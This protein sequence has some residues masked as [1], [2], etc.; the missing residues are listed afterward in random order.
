MATKK[1]VGYFTFVKV[2]YH[3]Y[4]RNSSDNSPGTCTMEYLSDVMTD[5]TGEEASKHLHERLIEV[6]QQRGMGN[7]ST[8]V[9]KLDIYHEE[10]HIRPDQYIAEHGVRNKDVIDAYPKYN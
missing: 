8:F 7:L 6:G 5:M 1:P 10:A 2:C 3:T 9:K 4:P